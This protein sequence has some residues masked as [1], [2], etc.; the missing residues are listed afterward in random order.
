MPEAYIVDAVRTPVG[1]T[2]GGLAR[3]STR[4][5]W[6]RT[7][8]KAARRAHRHRPGAPSTTSS[9]AASTRSARRPATSRAPRWLA[10]GLP[11]DVPGRHRRP[12]VRLEPAGRALRRAGRHE[13]HRRP[14]HRRR[15]AEHEPDPDRLGDDRRPSS[16][17]S[18][19]PVRRVEG[20][21]AR[22]GDRGVSPVPRR[23]ADRREVGHQPRGHGGVRAAEPRARACRPSTR[24]AS[25]REIVPVG[26]VHHRRGPAR[27]Q[28]REDG[29]RSTPLR[30]GGRLTAALSSQ[31]S[32]GAAALLIASE[33]AVQEHGLK[34]R[35]RIHHLQRPRRRPDLHAHRADPGDRS[36]RCAK[37]GLTIDDID[38]V[39]INEAFA[40]VVLAW[41]QGDRR[42]PGQGQRQR[43]RDRARPPARRHRRPADDHPA[44]RARAHR[45]PLRPADHVRGRRH[46]QRHH[47]RAPGLTHRAAAP[48]GIRVRLRPMR[49]PCS[50]WWQVRGRGVRSWCG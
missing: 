33:A 36:T 39:E 32:D 49:V 11:E 47:H 24:A 42:R 20:W 35:A 1:K 46:G 13:R 4:P 34:P 30:E 43:R 27:D 41:Q 16:T 44:P 7:C 3:A 17:A 37:T 6:A 2:N 50:R 18:P 28:P 14:G 25:T 9:S 29:R 19:T 12:P 26:D 21:I 5:T 38:L 8:I 23:R 40:S 31:I 15:R 48:Q 10:A 22:Y 45:R